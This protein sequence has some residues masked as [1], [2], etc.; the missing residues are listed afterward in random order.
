[1]STGAKIAPVLIVFVIRTRSWPLRNT[2]GRR[3]L[4]WGALLVLPRHRAASAPVTRHRCIEPTVRVAKSHQ[5]HRAGRLGWMRWHTVGADVDGAE[6]VVIRQVR[7]VGDGG[8]AA[9][10]VADR[11]LAIAIRLRGDWCSRA[12]VHRAAESAVACRRS[13]FRR[14]AVGRARARLG[15]RSILAGIA[16]RA[17]VAAHAAV[18]VVPAEV[19]LASIDRVSVAVAVTGVAS[20]RDAHPVLAT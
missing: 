3:A 18:I 4:S 13:A 11:R 1:M 20:D 7:I 8:D 10:S 5:A 6:V 2:P 14:R 9:I 17:T 15:A 16:R 19:G 12:H